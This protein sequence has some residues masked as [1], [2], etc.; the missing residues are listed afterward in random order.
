MIVAPPS[1]CGGLLRQE[2]L[3]AQGSTDDSANQTL[4]G[5][6]SANHTYLTRPEISIPVITQNIHDYIDPEYHDPTIT[7]L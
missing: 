6:A 4:E 3:A 5:H 7:Y 2:D 1:A